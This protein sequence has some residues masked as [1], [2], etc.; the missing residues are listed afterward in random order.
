M[1]TT[2]ATLAPSGIVHASP[3]APDVAFAVAFGGL[4]FENAVK[5]VQHPTNDNRWYVV[6]QEG[7]VRRFENREDVPAATLVVDLTDRV[8]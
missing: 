2:L 7:Y 5:L 4:A 3:D 6:E 8:I 1:R